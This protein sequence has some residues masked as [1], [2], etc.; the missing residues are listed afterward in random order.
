MHLPPSLRYRR[1]ALFWVILLCTGI[2]N[3]MLL[4]ALP[5]Q[6]NQL[7]QSPAALGAI[8]IIRLIPTIF[9]SLFAGLVADTFNRRKI[10]LVTQSV[11]GLVALTLGLLTL[12]GRIQ[13]WHIYG[14]LAINA[15]AFAFDLPAR[16]SLTPNLVP[17]KVLANALGVEVIAFQI[18]SLA[19]PL[20]NG[21]L[22]NLFGQQ[23]SYLVSAGF[24]TVVLVLLAAIGPVQQQKPANER[25]G[26]DWG[27]IKNG[28]T[29][30]FQ[31]A[32]IFPSMLLDFMATLLIRAD[33]LMPYIASDI[34][35]LNA[36]Q[37]GWLTAAPAMGAAIA[38]ITLSQVRQIRHQ[39]KLLLGVTV[40]IG[41]SA[42]I[43][44]LSRA[45]SLSL[46]M[47]MII[48]ASDAV[49]SIVRSA[50]RQIHTHDALRGRMIS[51]N[52]IFFI[53]GPYLGDVKSGYLGALI[54]VPQ[55]IAIGGVACLASVGWIARK[56]PALRQYDA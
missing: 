23:S 46:A 25:G 9:A 26:M 48:G 30:T 2:G 1:F 11:M 4:W 6:I 24:F 32:L 36:A 28:I 50:I 31:H 55:A 5:W 14:L 53:G 43:F 33:A 12:S 17:I 8:G 10:M 20:L 21:W 47:L 7:T 15:T 44:G 54:G 56:W 29:F 42:T 49:S 22:I 27:A 16:Y 18:G 40:V 37:Y 38:G 41:I 19:G 34:L 51:V 45:F 13:L 52:Q 3:R 35:G 39:G